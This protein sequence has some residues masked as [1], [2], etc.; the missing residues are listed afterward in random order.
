MEDIDRARCREEFAQA[1]LDDLRWAGLDWDEGPDVGGPFAPYVQSERLVNLRSAFLRLKEAGL[2]FPCTCSRRDVVSAALAPHAED[3]EAIYPGTCRNRGASTT[4]A[5]TWRFR[6]PDGEVVSFEDSR[7]GPQHYVG[8]RDFGDFI[9]WRRDDTPAY[10][11][12]VV[13]DDAAMGITEVVRGADLLVS[14]ARQLLVYR[15]L[16][17][18]PPQFHHAPL[19]L[20]AHGRRLA[21]RHDASSL[22]QLRERGVAARELLALSESPAP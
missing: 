8:G 10:E 7:L 9:V 5:V 19:V 20:D 11:L 14:T 3:A 2:L 1:A 4:E 6:V 21:K 12:A 17:L 22:R 15:A 13:V 16:G 18:E